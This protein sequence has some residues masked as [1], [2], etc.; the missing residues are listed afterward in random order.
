MNDIII[1]VAGSGKTT[2]CQQ[3]LSEGCIYLSH[4][5]Q[6]H[7]VNK[8]CQMTVYK[9]I[10]RYSNINIKTQIFKNAICKQVKFAHIIIDEIDELTEYIIKCISEILSNTDTKF[11]FTLSIDT[12]KSDIQ[13]DQLVNILS[14]CTDRPWNIRT[15][16]ESKRMD[17][18]VTE[19]INL[20]FNPIK[21]IEFNEFG[22]E[23]EVCSVDI[24]N[25]IEPICDRIQHYY[26]LG[27]VLLISRSIANNPELTN[28]CNHLTNICNLD[29][30]TASIYNESNNNVIDI[31]SMAACRPFESECVVLFGFI[32][33]DKFQGSMYT[34]LSRARRHILVIH[35][36]RFQPFRKLEE[37]SECGFKLHSYDQ[38]TPNIPP[39]VPVSSL[40]TPPC[41]N[42][43][44]KW[45]L[46]H[47]PECNFDYTTN[48][49]FSG[50]TEDI[51]H[52]Y[53]ILIPLMLEYERTGMCKS[54]ESI[55]HEKIN[56]LH[57]P[58]NKLVRLK[59]LYTSPSKCI[60]MWA[61]IATNVA[62]FKN[63]HYLVK[64][65]NH[66]EWV[67]EEVVRRALERMRDIVPRG[68]FEKTVS[69]EG[70]IGRIDLIAENDDIWEFK[71]TKDLEKNHFYQTHTY[72]TMCAMNWNKNINVYLFN[73]RS[74]ELW[75][76]KIVINEIN[77]PDR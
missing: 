12:I 2:I 29:V 17:Q 19:F 47:P 6:R 62:C 61:E 64:N 24:H 39:W 3:I 14:I 57:F 11:K 4:H 32:H 52:V 72:G 51:S 21:H 38:A 46:M 68:M 53:G 54:V 70:L 10:R 60:K 48:I 73:A 66:F 31:C 37:I 56:P 49:R 36:A 35:S 65:V 44:D 13:I 5:I 27:S 16:Q 26:S 77:P 23:V 74:C 28:V 50:N 18:Q 20:L 59:Q 25:N 40:V 58:Q 34:A 41:F 8:D 22:G 30:R 15:L 67:H 7:N 71:F 45:E 1:G 9:F 63:F 75:S 42:W 69:R 55:T 43:N 76:K 33:G